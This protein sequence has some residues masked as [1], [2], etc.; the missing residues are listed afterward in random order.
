MKRTF[1]GFML[2]V[3]TAFFSCK[4]D[5]SVSS[6]AVPI[7][8][9]I[10]TD[11]SFSIL[12]AAISRASETALLQQTGYFTLVAPSN[13]AFRAA[14]I[15][16]V[17][18]NAMPVTTVDSMVKYLF[19]SGVAKPSTNNDSL[20]IPTLGLPIYGSTYGTNTY[21]NGAVSVQQTTVAGTALLYKSSNLLLPPA[22]SLAQW[23]QSD[24]TLTLFNEAM[25]R[26]GI[27]NN[28]TT[29]WYTVFVPD[30]TAFAN[31]GYPDIAS[32]DNA[33][34]TALT[35]LINYNII[36]AAYFSNKLNGALSTDEG[37][38]I[39]ATNLG[40]VVQVAGHSN[41]SQLTVTKANILLAG[42]I[43]AHKING[44]LLP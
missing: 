40:T 11:T 33:D 28:L 31:A 2:L 7:Q 10:S 32:I 30:N 38:A 15:D 22:Y 35:N 37:A 23:L 9:V 24:P 34:I 19:I 4:K 29:G 44:V 1:I 41:T 20:F 8:T 14:G 39:V 27:I 18:I 42:N 21:F 13:D 6:T 26:T 3:S 17:A 43:I 5:S 12:N 16:T 36:N 25:I